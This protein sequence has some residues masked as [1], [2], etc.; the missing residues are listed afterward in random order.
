M[1]RNIQI[2]PIRGQEMIALINVRE[3]SRSS[4]ESA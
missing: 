2:Q 3:R 1:H 4:L